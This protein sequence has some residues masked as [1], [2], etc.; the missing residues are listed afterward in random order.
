MGLPTIAYWEGVPL[1]EVPRERLEEI[2]I[3]Q[4][5]EISQL[6]SSICKASV[7]HIRDLARSRRHAR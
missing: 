1:S 2:V 3:E 5:H 4:A 7:D 6:N